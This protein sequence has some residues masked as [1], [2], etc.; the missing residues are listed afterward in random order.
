MRKS[1][2]GSDESPSTAKAIN[3]VVEKKNRSTIHTM[4]KKH[5]RMWSGKP[6]D[7]N[8][9]EYS[10]YLVPGARPFKSRPYRA[11]P[12]TRESEGSEIHK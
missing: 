10:I 6:G 2:T 3:S 7:T 5:E 9:V 1:H 12:K 8:V 11:G 4:L